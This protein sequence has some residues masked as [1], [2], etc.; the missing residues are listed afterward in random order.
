MSRRSALLLLA[1][2]AP[3][4][5][6]AGARAEE[7]E[8]VFRI[9]FNDG[10]VTPL[11][12]EVPAN[13]RILLELHNLGKEPAEFESKELRKE[14]VLAPGAK[15]TLVIRTLDPGEYDFFDDFHLNAPPAVLVAK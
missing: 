13:R 6:T 9:E 1:M 10:V 2:A 5:I 11:R 8:P 3:L 4:A 14:K 7:E 15:S 12:I